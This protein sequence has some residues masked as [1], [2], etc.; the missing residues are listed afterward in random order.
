MR[1]YEKYQLGLVLGEYKAKG[2]DVESEVFFKLNN[3]TFVIDG[4]AERANPP[5]TVII[6]LVNSHRFDQSALEGRADAILKHFGDRPNVVVDFRYVDSAT[7]FAALEANRTF[8][9]KKHNLIMEPGGKVSTATL[10]KS[11]SLSNQLLSQWHE[12]AQSIR[13]FA[14]NNLD[15]NSVSLPVLDLYN[16]LLMPPFH[17]RPA[18]RSMRYEVRKNLFDLRTD[19]D[20]VLEGGDVD[21]KW[22]RQLRLHFNSMLHQMTDYAKK[23]NTKSLL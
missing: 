12:I 20:I 13:Q 23:K 22:V 18:E 17:F 4:L 11:E 14:R 8:V 15:E 21:E 10:S 3:R 2:Y 7:P 6:E 16:L 9:S 1:D 5:S 19:I